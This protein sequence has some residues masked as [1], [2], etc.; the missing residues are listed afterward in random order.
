MVEV[1]VWVNPNSHLWE[2]FNFIPWD[3]E[4]VWAISC[5]SSYLELWLL[6]LVMGVSLEIT[7]RSQV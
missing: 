6:V 5:R 1:T 7:D 3:V 4:S 2:I